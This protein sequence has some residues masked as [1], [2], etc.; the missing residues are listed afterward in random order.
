MVLDELA[1]DNED[2]SE[3]DDEDEDES[4]INELEF[5]KRTNMADIAEHHI[6]QQEYDLLNN[7][8][9]GFQ[10]VLAAIMR[11][12][13]KDKNFMRAISAGIGNS[14]FIIVTGMRMDYYWITSICDNALLISVK[15]I[16]LQTNYL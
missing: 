14:K 8:S 1:D 4:E 11:S 7:R 5:L 2:L 9:N 15:A 3:D 6:S 13:R 10:S 16:C 12:H